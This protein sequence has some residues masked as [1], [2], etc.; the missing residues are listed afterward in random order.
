MVNDLQNVQDIQIPIF[1]KLYVILSVL[2][3]GMLI[4]CTLTYKK[5]VFLP[6]FHFHT[7]TLSVAVLI[8]PLM[9]ILTDLI[10]EFFGKQRASFCVQI[11][12]GTNI[13]IAIIISCMD[14]LQATSW[15][16]VDVITFHRVFGSYGLAFIACLIAC[17]SAQ[18]VDINL[19]LW[20]KKL[21]KG[22]WLW[23]RTN[24]STAISLFIDTFIA[25]NLLA[26]LG[27]YPK[28][29]VWAVIISAYSYKLFVTVCNIPFFYI[30]VW[31]IKK[32]IIKQQKSTALNM[33]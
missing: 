32:F 4:T 1:E 9:F 14:S 27:V 13:I 31:A 2:F 19:Y 30:V 8:T 33:A 24:G 28:E 15:S 5:I 16:S 29:H 18:A 20:I 21:T 10:A 12:V 25:I 26:M 17:Y 7:F 3:S 11:A 23:L 6:V 22:K